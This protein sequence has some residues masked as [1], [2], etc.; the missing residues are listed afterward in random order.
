MLLFRDTIV[1]LNDM[2][3]QQTFEICALVLY[4]DPCSIAVVS[5][6]SAKRSAYSILLGLSRVTQLDSGDSTRLSDARPPGARRA[7]PSA[8]LRPCAMADACEPSSS[9]AEYANEEPDRTAAFG[10]AG[11]PSFEVKRPHA[12]P[13]RACGANVLTPRALPCAAPAQAG[14]A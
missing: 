5:R 6:L 12:A 10:R 8:A 7:A 11:A 2:N 13:G 4:R 1:T 3:K 14:R 9:T